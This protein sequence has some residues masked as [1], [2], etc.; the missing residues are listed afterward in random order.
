MK[1]SKQKLELLQHSRHDWL[2]KLQ[3]IKGNLELSNVDRARKII[4]DIIIEARQEAHL[5]SFGVPGF[6]EWLLTYNWYRTGPLKIGYEFMDQMNIPEHF[7][8]VLLS[9][10]ESCAASLEQAAP[11]S[12]D[13]ELYF[14][15]QKRRGW[16]FLNYSRI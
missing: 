9:W 5:T 7:D 15:F 13:H 2:N 10:A 11:D 12:V 3:I 14:I 6:A 1:R 8:S 16:L 4:D